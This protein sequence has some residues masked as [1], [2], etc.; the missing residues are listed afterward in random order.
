[1]AEIKRRNKS[2][3]T[4]SNGAGESPPRRQT[5]VTLSKDVSSRYRKN[6]K[7]DN[8]RPYAG[9]RRKDD[10]GGSAAKGRPAAS[11][12]R[13]ESSERP[14]GKSRPVGRPPLKRE[15]RAARGPELKAIVNR[16]LPEA[17]KQLREIQALLAEAANDLLERL[18]TMTGHG[19]D[20]IKELELTSDQSKELKKTLKP[21]KAKAET[22]VEVLQTMFEKISFHDLAGQRL[23][24]METFCQA[25]EEVLPPLTT[26]GFSERKRAAPRSGAYGDR[27][28]PS[29]RGSY[30][31]RDKPAA[32]G[33][34]SVE[35]SGKEAPKARKTSTLKGPKAKGEGMSQTEVN[36]LLNVKQDK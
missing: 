23:T 31:D 24:K 4:E 30:G 34:K 17:L 28:K 14:A 29:S 27:D 15:E 25:L 19:N 26:S 36:R 21:L 33:R 7:E 16:E 8:K 2:A 11:S 6:I 35:D 12:R 32:R 22:M 13:Y 5:R 18:E 1:M 3:E 20:L 10:D 9:T